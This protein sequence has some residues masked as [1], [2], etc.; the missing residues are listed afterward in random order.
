[1]DNQYTHLQLKSKHSIIQRS[2]LEVKGRY[3][4]QLISHYS[5]TMV[6]ADSIPIR[7]VNPNCSIEIICI[8]VVAKHW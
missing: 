1:M 5:I 7:E 8:I 2:S 6:F 4:L 3:Y